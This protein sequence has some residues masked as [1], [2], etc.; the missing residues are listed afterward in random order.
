[1]L[2]ASGNIEGRFITF[3]Y[4]NYFT[5][6]TMC[7]VFAFDNWQAVFPSGMRMGNFTIESDLKITEYNID[8]SKYFRDYF[9]I[10]S[11]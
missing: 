7:S 10:I 6:S 11:T 5:S 9:I 8:K 1:M 3:L 4:R 2:T